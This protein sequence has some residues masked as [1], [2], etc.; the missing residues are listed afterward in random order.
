[1]KKKHNF[2]ERI[3]PKDIEVFFQENEELILLSLKHDVFFLEFINDFFI[4]QILKKKTLRK[5]TDDEEIA[6]KSRNY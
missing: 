2:H 1:M 4:I 3:L 5:N 6:E